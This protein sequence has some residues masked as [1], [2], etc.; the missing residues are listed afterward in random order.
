MRAQHLSL[1]LAQQHLS[2]LRF[3]TLLIT[4]HDGRI[5]QIERTE[6][7]HIPNHS[8]PTSPEEAPTKESA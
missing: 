6:K 8:T 1:A 2:D 3:G 4:V 5:V 7:F